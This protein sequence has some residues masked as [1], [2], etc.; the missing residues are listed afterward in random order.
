[1]GDGR[2][3]MGDGRR[4]TGDGRWDGAWAW[5]GA[6]RGWVWQCGVGHGRTWGVW[7]GPC[8]GA[9][10]LCPS[11]YLA[12]PR[13]P[14][15]PPHDLSSNQ[16]TSSAVQMHL[17][18]AVLSIVEHEADQAARARAPPPP[19]PP[20]PTHPSSSAS[21][22]LSS[23]PSTLAASL[24]SPP[25]AF[26]SS[27]HPAFPNG[28]LG[29]GARLTTGERQRLHNLTL[30]TSMA[31]HAPLQ[32]SL[33]LLLVME[34]RGVTLGPHS[35][36]LALDACSRAGGWL[37]ARSLVR[38][39]SRRQIQ[40][41]AKDWAKALRAHTKEGGWM[42][43]PGWAEIAIFLGEARAAA[44]R[45][46][47]HAQLLVLQSG[48]GHGVGWEAVR[49]SG[50][51]QAAPKPQL[52]EALDPAALDPAFASRLCAAVFCA[53]AQDGECGERLP[54]L[55]A[56][57]VQ[58]GGGDA[59]ALFSKALKGCA[60]SRVRGHRNVPLLLLLARG[61]D[62]PLSQ[63]FLFQA[64]ASHPP[65]EPPPQ[66]QPGLPGRAPP[67]RSDLKQSIEQIAR[68]LG[69]IDEDGTL[70]VEWMRRTVRVSGSSPASTAHL[71]E[72]VRVLQDNGGT[73][74]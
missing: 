49:L 64:L 73:Q 33:A 19:P 5:M 16:H 26:E 27:L 41:S 52:E 14:S 9:T 50:L 56:D 39:A 24:A 72:L 68:G 65:D 53:A 74:V 70:P 57:W 21:T 29:A 55:Y 54:S 28:F 42:G 6:G 62:I 4:E 10:T 15:L 32:H 22:S 67:K 12:A 58:S 11:T 2:R 30:T 43:R 48:A 37:Q 18:L 20:S 47:P 1:M 13:C 69:L 25:D 34:R 45:L 61:R 8:R 35:I 31:A 7:R 66:Q 60:A 3:E 59:E 71:E 40:L 36:T 63:K 38:M 44:V 46:P 17:A 23:I 51:L